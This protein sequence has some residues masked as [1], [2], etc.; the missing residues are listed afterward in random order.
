M[1]SENTAKQLHD[2]STRGQTLSPEEQ[3]RLEEWYAVQDAAESQLLGM[4][5]INGSNTATLQKQIDAALM[6][7]STVTTRIQE[8]TAENTELKQEIHVLRN[9][10]ALL[11]PA[12]QVTA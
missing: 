6:Q 3:T 4:S 7:L 10:L 11:S 5:S 8:I 1:V 9:Q 2:K 12:M